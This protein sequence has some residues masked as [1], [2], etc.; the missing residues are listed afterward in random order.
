M[1]IMRKHKILIGLFLAFIAIFAYAGTP[2]TQQKSIAAY[3][4]TVLAGDAVYTSTPIY[5]G[6]YSQITGIVYADQDSA[7]DGFLIQQTGD[8]GCADSGATPNWDYSTA[9]SVT[10]ETGLAFSVEVVGRC[11]RVSYTNGATDQTEFRLFGSLKT[12]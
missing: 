3:T 4:T 12:N 9:Y 8:A 2:V 7:T 1:I 11:V 6:E 5:A 10:A